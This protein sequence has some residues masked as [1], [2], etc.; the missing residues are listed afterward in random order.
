MVVIIPENL[1]DLA[2]D[3]GACVGSDGIRG[4]EME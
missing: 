3:Q 4:V 2:C 1:I